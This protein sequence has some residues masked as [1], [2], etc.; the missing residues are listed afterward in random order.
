LTW[1]ATAGIGSRDAFPS[2]GRMPRIPD[3][4]LT[5]AGADCAVPG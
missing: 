1:P 5:A 3:P 2:D 4:V